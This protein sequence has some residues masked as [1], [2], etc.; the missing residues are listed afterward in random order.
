MGSPTGFDDHGLGVVSWP[1]IPRAYMTKTS[2]PMQSDLSTAI[3][4]RVHPFSHWP[5]SEVQPGQT[6]KA[7]R[8]CR[9]RAC[10]ASL[11]GGVR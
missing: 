4:A 11:V 3:D 9:A 6:G 1:K 7:A 8:R 10:T 2:P 5:P